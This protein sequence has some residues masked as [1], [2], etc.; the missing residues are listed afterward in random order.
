MG[1]EVRR[2]LLVTTGFR[3]RPAPAAASEMP[4]LNMP[5]PGT[6]AGIEA[7]ELSTRPSGSGGVSVTC[8]DCSASQVEIH[9]VTDIDDFLAE[10]GPGLVRR[11]VDR[12]RRPL[13]DGGHP[14][15]RGEVPAPS[16]GGRGHAP[17]RRAAE[18]RRLPGFGRPARTAVRRRS[19]H[20]STTGP[21]AHRTGQ[22]IPW[23]DDAPDLPGRASVRPRADPATDPHPGLA[24]QGE[25]RQLPAQCPARR[26][27]WTATS[28][29]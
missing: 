9:D 14:R 6:A 27:S 16:V 3:H 11:T 28:R 29:S 2:P 1:L 19:R 25:R 26:D 20:R 18:G 17:D 22:H 7:D 5:P 21:A 24:A 12:H 8:V 4:R 15:V 10:H 13:A 23:S